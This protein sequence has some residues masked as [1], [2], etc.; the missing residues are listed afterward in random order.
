MAMQGTQVPMYTKHTLFLYFSDFSTKK[1]FY[2]K[3]KINNTEKKKQQKHVK[4]NNKTRLTQKKNKTLKLCKTKTKRERRSDKI[5]CSPFPSTPWKNLSFKQTLEPVMRG[6]NWNHSSSKGT[7]GL[8]EDLQKEQ[9]RIEADS[10]FQMLSSRCFVEWL[11]TYSNLVE[12]D[13][14]YHNDDR[15]AASFV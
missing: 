9:K 14:Q 10:G 4:Q 7:W 13:R 6:K 3:K 1:Y 8:W 5:T 11:A 15:D 12:Y 2:M